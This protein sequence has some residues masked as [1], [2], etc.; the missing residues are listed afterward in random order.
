MQIQ[1][2]NT[3]QYNYNRTFTGKRSV[4]DMYKKVHPDYNAAGV[5]FV[6]KNRVN[7]L[8]NLM[9]LMVSTPL[10]Y[11]EGKINTKNFTE[12]YLEMSVPFYKRINT[13]ENYKE[14]CKS[15]APEISMIK[16][17]TKACSDYK[18]KEIDL[19]K[20]NGEIENTLEEYKKSPIKR[21]KFFIA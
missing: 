9:N 20:F 3:Y 1:R 21:T 2:I 7:S 11:T 10:Q 17:I 6:T 16:R 18:N 12:N 13:G 19:K 14:Y 4:L 15:Y 8:P 5:A